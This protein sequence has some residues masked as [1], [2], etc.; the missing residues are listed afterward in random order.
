MLAVFGGCASA[1]A[2]SKL[3]STAA[4]DHGCPKEQVSV[5]NEDTDIWAYE[6]DVCG[7]RRKYRD[8]GNDKEWQFVDV[9]DGVPGNLRAK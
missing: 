3:L 5:V 6:V 4:F 2:R 8:F 7:K 9:T 1:K